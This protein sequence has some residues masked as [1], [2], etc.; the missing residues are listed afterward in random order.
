MFHMPGRSHSGPLPP[1]SEAEAEIQLR[2]EGHVKNLHV[3]RARIVAVGIAVKSADPDEAIVVH[4]HP[5]QPR[6]IHRQRDHVHWHLIFRERRS[7]PL[8]WVRGR[9][10]SQRRL[11]LLRRVAR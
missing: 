5:E 2:L 6:R 1:L 8:S 10:G 9:T 11:R 4:A 7:M 3:P